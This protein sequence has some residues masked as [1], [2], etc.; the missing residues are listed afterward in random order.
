MMRQ[1]ETRRPQPDHQHL[2][3]ARGLRHRAADIERVPAR[4]QRIDLEAPGQRR[5]RSFRMLRLRL[6]DIDRL[7]LLIDAGLHAVVADAVAGAAI[8]G[9]STA[10]IANAPSATPC[11][12]SVC[13][14]EIF[15]SS[16][17]PASVTL[18]TVFWNA[19]VLR[20]LEALRAAN[21][22]PGRG[23]RCSN[24]SGRAPGSRPCPTS[25]SAKPSRWRQSCSGRRIM[26]TPSSSIV[27]TGHQMLRVDLVRHLEQHAASCASPCRRRQR[28]P[29]GIA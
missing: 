13:I 11:A 5:A 1:R 14:S 20:V 15:S 6:R 28:R 4:Q 2:V 10:I 26:R 29:R 22:C 21:P 23:T 25:V 24:S 3:A 17:Q 16:G 27:S 12:R 7:L 18:K 8:I 19:P 9:L